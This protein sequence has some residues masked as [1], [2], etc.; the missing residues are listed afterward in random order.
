MNIDEAKHRLPA[1]RWSGMNIEAKYHFE[2]MD[3]QGQNVQ[4][5]RCFEELDSKDKY[6]SI[7][8]SRMDIESGVTVKHVAR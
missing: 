1:A 6:R 4:T 5:V 2:E 7:I 3:R 8:S